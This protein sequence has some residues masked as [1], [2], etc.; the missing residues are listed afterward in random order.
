[1]EHPAANPQ[2]HAVEHAGQSAASPGIHASA[3]VESLCGNLPAP[4]GPGQVL[5]GWVRK[6]GH[7]VVSVFADAAD[8]RSGAVEHDRRVPRQAASSGAVRP[9]VE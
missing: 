7:P 2:A 9:F 1:M 6:A 3:A 4:Q 8:E 5:T